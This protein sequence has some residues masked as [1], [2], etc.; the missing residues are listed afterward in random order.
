M[1][2]A[3]MVAPFGSLKSL[4]SVN[5]VPETESVDTRIRIPSFCLKMA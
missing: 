5:T 1:L 4:V 2:T 3:F